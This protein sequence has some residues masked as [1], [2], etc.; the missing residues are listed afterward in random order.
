MI[1]NIFRLENAIRNQPEQ[2]TVYLSRREDGKEPS[3]V[4]LALH[5][6][7]R[8]ALSYRDIPF[9]STQR[10]CALNNGY[11][12]LALS[13]GPDAW[14]L[15]DGLENI[16]RLYSFVQRRYR[17]RLKW[18]LWGTSAG[19]VMMHRMVREHGEK[20]QGIIGT[21]PVYD[22]EESFNRLP[23]CRKGWGANNL[24]ELRRKIH[25]RNPPQFIEHLAYH[26]YLII[27]GRDDEV[28]PPELHSIRFRSEVDALGGNVRLVLID[29]GH[30][31]ENYA[32]YDHRFIDEYLQR[33]SRPV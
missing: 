12:F 19:G 13:N 6:S 29:G 1:E 2:G 20:V 27:Q 3:P 33:W 15:D 24:K 26:E 4:L 22:L 5:G 10:D 21:F 7:G 16:V 8:H 28:V 14:G 23:S 17:V 9:Y 18:V 31:I 30:S 11:I 25:G 32:V